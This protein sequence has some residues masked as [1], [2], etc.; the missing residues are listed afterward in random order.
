MKSQVRYEI[1]KVNH[2]VT[3]NYDIIHK[4]HDKEHYGDKVTPKVGAKNGYY[5]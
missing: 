2:F 1:C 3:H 5:W 4:I